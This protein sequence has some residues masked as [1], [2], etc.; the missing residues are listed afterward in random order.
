MLCHMD[1]EIL[2]ISQWKSKSLTPSSN[3]ATTCLKRSSHSK[4]SVLE[5]NVKLEEVVTSI[6]LKIVGSVSENTH[7][8][9]LDWFC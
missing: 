8:V 1:V 7:L 6:L 5:A 4:R 3:A 2:R 9:E